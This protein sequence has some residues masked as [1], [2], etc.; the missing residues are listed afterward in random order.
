MNE[1]ELRDAET[2]L[3]A[4]VSDIGMQ[5]LL[6]EIDEA[7]AAGTA[8]EKALKP[9]RRRT[10]SRVPAGT[11]EPP[12]FITERLED[13]PEAESD[14]VRRNQSIV[15]STRPLSRRERVALLVSALRRIMIVL[16]E[17]EDATVRML[18]EPPRSENRPPIRSMQF[19]PDPENE[20]LN[21]ESY[22]IDGDRR[23]DQQILSHLFDDVYGELGE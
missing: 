16:P 17:I 4:L 13:M 22:R 11:P 14:V 10:Q 8:V 1:G 21:E 3:R 23:E 5:W 12:P 6:N 9:R 19:A 7:I 18:L 20:H 15:I 2:Q